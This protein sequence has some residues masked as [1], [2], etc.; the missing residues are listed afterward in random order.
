V[1]VV[2][3]SRTKAV[4]PFTLGFHRVVSVGL[5]EMRRNKVSCSLGANPKGN[6]VFF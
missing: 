5:S 4:L 6:C 2:A 3:E 1:D